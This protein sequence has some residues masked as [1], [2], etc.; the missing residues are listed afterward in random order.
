[1]T[2]AETSQEHRDSLTSPNPTW[3]TI[4]SRDQVIKLM[5]AWSDYQEQ[6]HHLMMK[7][8]VIMKKRIKTQ[9]IILIMLTRQEITDYQCIYIENFARLFSL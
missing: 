4:A 8:Q 6:N 5:G 1:M 7:L 3:W 2:G 9:V